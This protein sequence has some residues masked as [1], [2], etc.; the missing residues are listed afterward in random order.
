MRP[1]CCAGVF[2]I[3]SRPPIPT[4]DPP[5][6]RPE[7]LRPDSPRKRRSGA[8]CGKRGARAIR[9]G[10][11]GQPSVFPACSPEMVC[12]KPGKSTRIIILLCGLLRRNR[13]D[14]ADRRCPEKRGGA[15]RCPQ[16]RSAA[17]PRPAVPA[18]FCKMKNGLSRSGKRANRL[19]FKPIFRSRKLNDRAK[20]QDG[21]P[22][23]SRFGSAA[24]DKARSFPSFRPEPPD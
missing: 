16:R 20:T 19:L 6:P 10:K 2:S 5:P 4:A 17:A 13:Q 21:Y 3:R 11:I 9:V 1:E 22:A 18:T 23:V 7:S 14:A 12:G 24:P 15:R 8:F